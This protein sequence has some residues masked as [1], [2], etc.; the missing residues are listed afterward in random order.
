MITVAGDH[1][2]LCGTELDRV[3]VDGR[4]RRHCPA[5]DRVV[6]RNSKPVASV[7]VRDGDEVLLGKRDV[8]PHRGL[9]GVPGGNLEHDEHP[10]A[11]ALRELREET[12]VRADPDDLELVS[13]DHIAKKR[14]SV[15]GVRYVVDRGA[16]A[17]GPTAR[18]ET[19]AARFDTLDAFR[20][21]GGISPWE[22]DLLA[23]VFDR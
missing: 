3:R 21:D 9:W 6:W 15:V 7:V 5:C 23:A 22:R 20:A 19:S 18:D 4:D 14:Q 16:T 13:V 2:P 11:G 17:G 8:D 10:A 1:C 12:G